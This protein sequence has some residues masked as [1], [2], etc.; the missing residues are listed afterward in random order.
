[1]DNKSGIYFLDQ[2]KYKLNDVYENSSEAFRGLYQFDND[3]VRLEINKKIEAKDA[4]SLI[5]TKANQFQK[6]FQNDIAPYPGEV[7]NVTG[8]ADEFKPREVYI[9]NNLFFK[10]YLNS[11]YQFG[12]C[13][14]DQL[15]YQG[16]IGYIYCQKNKSMYQIEYFLDKNSSDINKKIDDFISSLKCN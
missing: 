2:K 12:S 5:K 13:I 3:Y 4:D 7:S 16:A 11:R 1:M 10:A 14:K 9:N 8:C 6:L 15:V